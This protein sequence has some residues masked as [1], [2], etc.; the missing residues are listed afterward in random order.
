MPPPDWKSALEIYP[1]GW[2]CPA[3]PFWIAGWATSASG[4]VVVDVRAW[5]GAQPFLGLC[6]LPRPD[7]EI[8]ARG[9]A[10]AP[11][12]GFSFLLHAVPGATD[13]RVEVCD[14][15]GRWTEIFRHAVT[16]APSLPSANVRITNIRGHAH[17]APEAEPLLRLLR[18]KHAR[19]EQSWSTLAREI[20][21]HEHSETFDV[22]PSEPFKGALEQLEFRAAVQYGHLLVTGWVAHREQEIT[23]LTA[24][25]DTATPLPLVHGLERADAR[26]LFPDLVDA[27]HSRF[28]GYLPVPAHLPHPLALRIFAELASGKQELVFLKRFRPVLTSGG[29]TDLPAFSR[30]KFIC[31]AWALRE[32]GWDEKWAP[33]AYP[34]IRQAAREEYRNAAPAAQPPRELF[35]R[36]AP[37]R[38]KPL[39]VTLVTHNLNYEGAPLFLLEYARYLAALPGWK[40]RIIS[41]AEGPLRARFAEAGLAV[42]VIDASALLAAPDDAGF[43]SALGHLA[44][45]PAWSGGDVII[46]NTMVA[47]WAV[48]VAQ[49][50]HQPSL[51]YIHESVGPRR[52]FALQ[53]GAAALTRVEQA[54]ALATR[55][56]FMAHA[57]QR[58]FAALGGKNNFRVTP[59]WIDLARIQAYDTAHDRTELRRDLGLPEDTVV[60]ANIGAVLPRKGQHVFLEAI[61]LLQ[62]RDLSAP[63]A[64][65]IVGVKPGIDPYVDLLRHTIASRGLAHV[66]LIESSSDPYRYFKAADVCVCSSLEEA[67]PRVVM[68]AAAFGR[69]IVTTDVDG[70]PELVGPEEAW[71]VPPDDAV[72]LAA[73]MHA[74][75]DAHVGGTRTKAERAQEQ[76]TALSDAAVRLPEHEAIIRLVAAA[77]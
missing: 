64:F 69:L 29:G 1:E 47:F 43:A 15:H 72:N 61:A 28:A 65:L 51:F 22:A 4:L 66:Q 26:T 73:A 46:A 39:Q 68:E 19:P 25:L 2:R 54:F 76:I 34:A 70:I 48:H 49:Q 5:L 13:L 77:K 9:H 10:G 27:E 60:F 63:C 11:Q 14:Q 30:W 36:I 17:A 52:F 6:G 8:A 12:A 21:A 50:L 42:D 20:L 57:S 35:D 58:A 67:L 32:A 37:D 56:G 41:A 55:V 71:L 74:A 53:F 24:Y 44:Q 33:G 59:G 16:G 40:V 18:A 7:K 45:H 62:Q 38:T 75:F 31:A 23:R 3:G